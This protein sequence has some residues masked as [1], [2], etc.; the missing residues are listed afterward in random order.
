MVRAE[1]RKFRDFSSRQKGVNNTT[2]DLSNKVLKALPSLSALL[3]VPLVHVTT[4]IPA[5]GIRPE[6]P[7][8]RARIGK[9]TESVQFLKLRH[10]IQQ[11]LARRRRLP[12]YCRR[13]LIILRARWHLFEK[14]TLMISQ[15]QLL[16]T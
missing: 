11:Y 15:N 5:V 8:R 12:K 1:Y 9:A 14:T 10:S 2:S 6:A 7:T 13:T 16:A 3:V 4:D